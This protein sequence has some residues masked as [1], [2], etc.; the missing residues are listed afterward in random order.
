MFSSR[1]KTVRSALYAIVVDKIEEIGNDVN[2]GR[3]L[4]AKILSY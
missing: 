3:S 2:S 4:L 1:K